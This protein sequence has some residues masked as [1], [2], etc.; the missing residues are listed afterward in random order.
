MILRRLTKHV[1]DQN[2]FAVALDFVIVVVGILLAFQ[3]TNWNESRAE[4]ALEVNYLS[5][6]ER[7]IEY[8]IRVLE[9]SIVNLEGQQEA[10]QTLYEFRADPN[11]VLEPREL[12]RLVARGVFA[13]ERADINQTTFE[14]LKS[15]GQLSLIKSPALVEALQNLSAH[16]AMSEVDKSEDFQFTFRNSDPLLI[17][18]GDF[19]NILINDIGSM[20]DRLSWIKAQ[21]TAG[22][23]SEFI[24]SQR[25]KNIILFRTLFGQ[26]RMEGYQRMLD[27]HQSLL[28]LIHERQETLGVIA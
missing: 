24:R 19:D 10:R 21:P 6:M 11:A 13:L 27:R 3:I 14:T 12:D 8:S 16:V 26:L 2:W 23:S 20:H 4:R 1:N 9:T 17:S 7:D 5:A 28:T 25:L 22:Y 15:T 18:E